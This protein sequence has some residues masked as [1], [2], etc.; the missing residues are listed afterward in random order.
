MSTIIKINTNGSIRVD[1]DFKLVDAEGNE[2]NLNGR[3]SISLCRCGLSRKMP[4]CDSSHKGQFMQ[5]SKAYELPP[6]AP[7]V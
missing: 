7:K 5:E 1:G 3:T 6:P 4:F 2:F